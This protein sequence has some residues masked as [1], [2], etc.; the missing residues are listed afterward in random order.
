MEKAGEEKVE[1]F[2]FDDSCLEKRAIEVFALED[3][4]NE[5]GVLVHLLHAQE[6]ARN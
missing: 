1:T 2:W 3:E 6:S 4:D 5:S